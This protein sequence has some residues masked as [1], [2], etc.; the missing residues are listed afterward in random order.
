M[1]QRNV[2][3]PFPDQLLIPAGGFLSNTLVPMCKIIR[4][5]FSSDIFQKESGIKPGFPNPG[6]FQDL[7]SIFQ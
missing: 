7:L 2:F 3:G 5:A 4:P 1:L 6:L